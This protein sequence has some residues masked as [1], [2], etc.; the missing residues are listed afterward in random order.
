MVLYTA[1]FRLGPR[2]HLECTRSDLPFF[3]RNHFRAPWG[4]AIFL[5]VDDCFWDGCL[6]D[7]WMGEITN[8]TNFVLTWTLLWTL[9][10][11][12]TMIFINAALNPSHPFS[13][14]GYVQNDF[15]ACFDNI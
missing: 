3:F 15:N 10:W 4:T 2:S 6:G 8:F 11:T 9:R 7:G 13:S 12:W 5:N 1:R 14:A